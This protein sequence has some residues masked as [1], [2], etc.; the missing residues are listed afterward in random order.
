MENSLLLRGG[1]PSVLF[2][3]STDWKRPTH[4]NKRTVA[5]LKVY[6]FKPKYHSKTSSQKYLEQCL[7]KYIWEHCGPE[8]WNIKL[9]II[10]STIL[11]FWMKIEV[12]NIILYTVICFF[13][14]LYL[15]FSYLICRSALNTST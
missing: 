6:Q 4:I 10:I 7:I 1:Q 12:E 15:F 5:L 3:S 11:I 2:R 9:N 8:K 13:I 14:Y